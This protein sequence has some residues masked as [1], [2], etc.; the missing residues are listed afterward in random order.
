MAGSI[1]LKLPSVSTAANTCEFLEKHDVMVPAQLNEAG[2]HNVTYSVNLSGIYWGIK[3]YI[4]NALGDVYE[5][6]REVK[7]LAS[8]KTTVDAKV[9][10]LLPCTQPTVKVVQ[11][12]R[13]F[14]L[15]FGIPKCCCCRPELRSIE[16]CDIIIHNR[17][18]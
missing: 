16:D 12:D 9:R 4:V 1:I 18:V 11:V 3:R 5:K 2:K 14:H 6:I 7:T 17:E 8:L 13:H 15:L 10:S